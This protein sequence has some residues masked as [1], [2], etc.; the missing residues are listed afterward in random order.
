MLLIYNFGN[1]YY[2]VRSIMVGKTHLLS[3]KT[4]QKRFQSKKK[5][6]VPSV[7]DSSIDLIHPLES[8]LHAGKSIQTSLSCLV[9]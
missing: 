9:V 8:V 2:T 7:T 3:V 5:D 6:S 4:I 1:I